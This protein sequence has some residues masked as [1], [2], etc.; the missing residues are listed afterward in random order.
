MKRFRFVADFTFNADSAETLLSAISTHLGDC[1]RHLANERP[2]G[3]V[4]QHFKIE[5]V[6][7]DWDKEAAARKADPAFDDGTTDLHDHV[8]EEKGPVE[9]TLDPDSPAGKALAE[10][11][12]RE[13]SEREAR[14]AQLANAGK[15]DAEIMAEFS[16]K[17][18]AKLTG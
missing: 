18:Q 5:E 7:V 11:Q 14:A 15:S 17:E 4:C 8:L 13:K 2:L 16:A 10:Q 6:S 12:A 1:S 3:E 9:L